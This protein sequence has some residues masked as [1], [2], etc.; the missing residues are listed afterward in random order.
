MGMLVWDAE[1]RC[2]EVNSE[3]CR[4]TG[5]PAVELL[6]LGT[7]Q[8]VAGEGW[9]AFERCRERSLSLGK[10]AGEC[11]LQRKDGHAIWVQMTLV[12]VTPQS[13]MAF[14]EDITARKGVEKAVREFERRFRDVLE[15]VALAAVM[16]DET[17]HVVFCNDFLLEL[18]GWEREEVLQRDW[19]ECFLPQDGARGLPQAYQESLRQGELPSETFH[20]IVTRQGQRRLMAWSTTLFRDAQGRICGVTSIGQDITQLKKTEQEL[21][22]AKEQYQSLLDSI[23]GTVWELEWPSGRFIYISP[24]VERMFGHPLAA[25]MGNPGFLT[26]L[27]HP[28]DRPKV[29]EQWHERATKGSN[30]VQEFR[31]RRASGAYCWVRN[32]VTVVTEGG[33]PAKLRGILLDVTDRVEAEQAMVLHNRELS[34]YFRISQMALEMESP[35]KLLTAMVGEI[36]RL[37]E[38]P[39][40]AIEQYHEESGMMV[41]AASTGF[42]LAVQGGQEPPSRAAGDCLSGMAA[43]SGQ[44][45]IEMAAAS[46]EERVRANLKAMGAEI[47]LGIPIQVQDRVFGVL[48]LAHARAIEVPVHLTQ[49]LSS[50][51]NYLALIIH[52]FSIEL[53]LAENEAG[54]KGIYEHSPTIMCLLDEQLRMVRANEAAAEFAGISTSKLAGRDCGQLLGCAR[55]NGEAACAPDCSCRRL[56]ELVTDTFTKGTQYFREEMSVRLTRDGRKREHYF[57]VSTARL[58]IRGHKQLLL[59]VENITRLREAQARVTEQAA[60]LDIARDA[61]MV[62]GLDGRVIY[63]NKAAEEVYGWAARDAIGQ[64]VAEL[65]F[66][67]G[68]AEY[69]QLFKAVCERGQWSGEIRQFNGAGQAI[70]VRCRC[71]LVRDRDGA[72]KSVLVVNTNI[73]DEKRIEAQLLRSQRLQS[74][75]TLASGIAHD[76]NNVLT[77]VALVAQQML[78]SARDEDRP[79]LETM[80][81]CVTRGS[82]IL[83]QL[84][85]FARGGEGVKVL[86]Q[87]R[88]LLK[89]V[90]QVIKETFPRLINIRIDY[91]EQPWPIMADSTQISQVLMNLCVNARDAMPQ[92][93]NLLLSA[94]NCKIST[95]QLDKHP[96]AKPGPYVV[97]RVKDT[98]TGI[99]PA[100]LD[101]IFDPFF[102]TKPQGEGTGLGLSTVMGI[103]EGHGGFVEV[104][105]KP[106][107]GSEFSVW[108][109][110]CLEVGDTVQQA[111]AVVLPRAAGEM[112]LIVDDEDAVV[113]LITTALV[114]QGYRTMSACN[115]KHALGVFQEHQQEI[116]AVVTDLMMPEMDGAALVT[117]V[118]QIKPD[119]KV[120]IMSGLHDDELVNKRIAALAHGTIAKPFTRHDL[121]RM[122]ESVL[123]SETVLY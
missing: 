24:Q 107:A 74:I 94:A 13:V 109:P 6:G 98:G 48:S 17:G 87:P 121:L 100:I 106:G 90:E 119:I 8:L 27:V 80:N 42:E 117:R 92:G 56:R 44:P 2:L 41:Y 58:D 105:S 18:T 88:H 85:I 55:F 97:F 68:S 9:A 113:R 33:R 25:W 52:R 4:I 101:L 104:A 15:N 59:C 36:Q 78:E 31:L 62:H 49:H 84:L 110:A 115:G 39:M 65:I 122:I 91:H 63:W 77:P 14:F 3:A 123:R 53:E 16:L 86:L 35:Q 66:P 71:T 75:G 28:E 96:H 73:T 7:R 67:P 50:L 43:Q 5:Y 29:S 21:V 83:R 93:G 79:M 10:A 54:L 40:V 11:V 57:L 69:G 38:F 12:R 34:I 108:L 61:I 30:H 47:Y 103:A 64:Q 26:E 45:V 32:L 118:R 120:I 89:E 76:L 95:G 19:F 1:G 99:A 102:T 116:R 60:L 81:K 51:A 112:V 70:L 46:Q 72:P 22:R 111:P 23:E 37:T 20:D 82:G 114:R